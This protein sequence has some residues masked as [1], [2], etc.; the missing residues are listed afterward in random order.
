[1]G[2]KLSKIL[3]ILEKVTKGIHDLIR[4][5][6]NVKEVYNR[7]GNLTVY[8]GGSIEDKAG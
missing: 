3:K 7:I 1:M 6:G 8:G 2:T 4:S 5:R